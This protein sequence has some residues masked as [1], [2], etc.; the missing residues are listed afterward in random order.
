MERLATLPADLLEEARAA[1]FRVRAEEDRLVVR[2]PTAQKTLVDRILADKAEVL[3]V[4]ADE[5]EAE[6]AWRVAV[7]APQIPA[8]GTIP[9]MVARTCQTGPADCLSCGDPMEEGQ[10]YVC[11]AC[12]EAAR[13]VVAADE[14]ERKA[15]RSTEDR[16]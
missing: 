6:V 13:R 7:M 11:R 15:R 8:T 14:A 9:F 5:A 1:G 3:A 12:A 10:R 2:G 16:S 4:L